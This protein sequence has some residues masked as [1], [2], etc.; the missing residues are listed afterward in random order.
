[1]LCKVWKAEPG[2]AQH[3]AMFSSKTLSGHVACPVGYKEHPK[4]TAY[5][6]F[7]AN[8]HECR[9][10]FTLCLMAMAKFLQ[11]GDVGRFLVHGEASARKFPAAGCLCSFSTAFGCANC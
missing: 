5:P 2:L 6:V 7:W 10:S 11:H 3:R 1:M 9:L 8:S 4:S